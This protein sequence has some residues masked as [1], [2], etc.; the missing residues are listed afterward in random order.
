[1][2]STMSYEKYRHLLKK[3]QYTRN[4]VYRT[5]MPLSPLKQAPWDLSQHC[6]KHCKILYWNRHWLPHCIFL[7]LI[8]GLKSLPFQRCFQFSEKPKVTGYQI[9]SVGR[10][11]HLGDFI[12][13]QKTLHETCYISGCV[14]MTKLPITSC[15]QLRLFSSYRISQLMK[16]IEVVLLINCLA[17]RGILLMDNMVPVKKHMV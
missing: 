9:W 11:S 5:M 14:I 17:W 16:N 3:I 4:I 1:M 2:V 8:D 7:N 13:H 12:F 6:S 15:P 10:L